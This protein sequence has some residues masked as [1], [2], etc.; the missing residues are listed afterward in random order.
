MAILIVITLFEDGK[1]NK[2][3]PLNTL[4]LLLS[5]MSIRKSKREKPCDY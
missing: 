4:T 1:Y 2:R 3:E 5:L